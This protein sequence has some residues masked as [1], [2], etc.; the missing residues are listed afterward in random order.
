MI[1]VFLRLTSLSMIISRSIY[2][3]AN[4]IKFILFNGWVI[5]NFM[6]IP[7]L[8]IPSSFNGHLVYFHVFVLLWTLECMYLFELQFCPDICPG[9][10]LLDYMVVLS[11]LTHNSLLHD[12]FNSEFQKPHIYIDSC[13]KLRDNF[14]KENFWVLWDHLGCL[15]RTEDSYHLWWIIHY[16]CWITNTRDNDSI[17]LG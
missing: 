1:F 15:L 17:N 12:L 13:S 5:F 14:Y 9:V 3:A 16:L 2:V 6:Y 7:H 4:D 8:F 10:G 11:F